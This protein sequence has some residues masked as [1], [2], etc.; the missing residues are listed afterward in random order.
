MAVITVVL[1]SKWLYITLE[2]LISQAVYFHCQMTDSQNNQLQ[3]KTITV[4]WLLILLLPLLGS[5]VRVCNIVNKQ[6][7]IY[8]FYNLSNIVKKKYKNII[9]NFHTHKN[10]RI[11]H[12]CNMMH[13]DD[14]C[15]FYTGPYHMVVTC[16][17]FNEFPSFVLCPIVQEKKI[18]DTKCVFQEALN[19]PKLFNSLV[20][21]N[22]WMFHQ[23]II[24]TRMLV[25]IIMHVKSYTIIESIF[26]SSI[27]VAG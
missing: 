10:S 20:F 14:R 15:F 1:L 16:P 18:K 11:H 3:V 21:K 2:I 4:P 8:I 27:S 6:I 13:L 9:P 5:S 25:L 17:V 7:S 24:I 22:N 12:T 26:T 19:F 23:L